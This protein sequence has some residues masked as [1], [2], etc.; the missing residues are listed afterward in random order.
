MICLLNYLANI[1]HRQGLGITPLCAMVMIEYNWYCSHA[2][3]R[4]DS[5]CHPPLVR[6]SFCPNKRCFNKTAV[7]F[8]HVCHM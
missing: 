7:Y 4:Y 1:G 3:T 8:I 2:R 6:I 5:A